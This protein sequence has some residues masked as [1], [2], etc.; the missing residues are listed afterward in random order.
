VVIDLSGSGS[1]P[2]FW[3]I[4]VIISAV[5]LY[6]ALKYFLHIIGHL[7]EIFWR[8]CVVVVLILIAI[9]ILNYFGVI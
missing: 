8:G 1:S 7:I 5:V 2:L 9:A 3:W 6:V 4:A